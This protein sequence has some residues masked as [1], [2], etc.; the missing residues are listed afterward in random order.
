MTT[1]LENLVNLGARF[2][3][4][5]DVC[6]QALNAIDNLQRLFEEHQWLGESLHMPTVLKEVQEAGQI[7][8]PKSFVVDVVF[9]NRTTASRRTITDIPR[10]GGDPSDEEMA[11]PLETGEKALVNSKVKPVPVLTRYGLRDAYPQYD[12]VLKEYKSRHGSVVIAS[13]SRMINALVCRANS[14]ITILE[15]SALAVLDRWQLGILVNKFPGIFFYCERLPDKRKLIC[16]A[17]DAALLLKEEIR[18]YPLVR[19]TNISYM[20]GRLL[21]MAD[22]ALKFSPT[23]A[24]LTPGAPRSNPNNLRQLFKVEA[25]D[26]Y[27]HMWNLM[28]AQ[29]G[30]FHKVIL[31]TPSVFKTG[32]RPIQITQPINLVELPVSRTRKD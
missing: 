14:P 26:L 10:D 12:A 31:K 1:N 6:Q 30:I 16:L 22:A 2:R 32:Y 18:S 23:M 4:K 8:K 29:V 9:P 19:Y 11:K 24:F 7:P 20:F 25:D 13:V 27:S 15:L 21:D 3:A 17:P 5:L 28:A